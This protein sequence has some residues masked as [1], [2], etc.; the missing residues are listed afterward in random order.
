MSA[1]VG[2]VGITE[3]L[4]LDARVAIDNGY[5]GR[6][7]PGMMTFSF[8]EG[9]VIQT[10]CIHETGVAFLHMDF[11]IKGP[12][13][14]GDTIGVIVEVTEQ[15]PTSKGDRGLITTRNEVVN[16]HG[17]VVLVYT[18]VRLTGARASVTWSALLRTRVGP[19]APAVIADDEVW[20]G[21]ELMQRAAG[22]ADWLDDVAAPANSPIACLLSTSA[23][24][25]RPDH[26]RR[27]H[28]PPTGAARAA[29]HGGRAVGVRRTRWTARSSWPSPTSPSLAKA[30]AAR[31]GR[32]VEL[33]PDDPG[34][35]TPA[36]PGPCR[37]CRGRHPPHVGHER[38]PEGGPL[39]AGSPRRSGR[40][41]RLAAAA[42]LRLRLRLVVAA[43]PHRRPRHAVRRPRRRCHAAH[44]RRLQ[45]RELGRPRP[46]WRHARPARAHDDRH[47]ARARR[48]AACRRCERCSTGRRRSIPTR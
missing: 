14:V 9:L 45:H 20:T 16:Q 1:F 34:V 23:G 19:D 12:V 24:A 46:P 5:A 30:V 10:G 39:P 33:L 41:Q 7:V 32:R 6:L 11:D 38:A 42:R 43:A 3:P 36:R 17:D 35:G 31:T 18:P 27:E 25:I 47:P 26:R 13:Y 22:T 15:R 40:G 2:V 29:A 37:R 4:F 44:V 48:P 21:D 28:A 8:A